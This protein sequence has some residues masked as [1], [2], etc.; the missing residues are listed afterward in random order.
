[1]STL[2]GN[3]LYEKNHLYSDQHIQEIA[4]L[5]NTLVIYIKPS[6]DGPLP[7]T[8]I[9]PETKLINKS[10]INTNK[11]III[12]GISNFSSILINN[13]F[14]LTKEE[15]NSYTFDIEKENEFSIMTFNVFYNNCDK[16]QEIDE[17]IK[18]PKPTLICTQEAN[19]EDDY[20]FPNYTFIGNSGDDDS[21][22]IVAAYK[23]NNLDN[24]DNIDKI[25]T[26]L[27]HNFKRYGILFD[28]KNIKIANLHLAGGRGYDQFLFK[29]KDLFTKILNFKLELL[30]KIIEKKPDII[31][32]DFNSVLP[33]KDQESEDLYLQSQYEYFKK[34]L[35]R[36]LNEEEIKKIKDINN[37]PYERLI[38]SGYTY[39]KPENN[40]LFTNILGK[41]IV[42]CI[43]Y[44]K[45]K[46]KLLSCNI[47]DILD[48]YTD[49]KDCISD[50]NPVIAD[51]EIIELDDLL[52]YKKKYFK[53]KNKYLKNKKN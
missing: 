40:N 29:S 27:N 4:F 41:T 15:Y 48:N 14:N 10:N 18:Y 17:K 22:E 7:T 35:Q 30:K 45:E 51:F 52:I 5:L 31:L 33:M 53:Y 21:R 6:F 46:L 16:L 25:T 50:H 2:T 39:A 38:S 44:K 43:W 49:K 8:K 19:L 3:D 23:L 37:I 34:K 28:Y 11:V 42:D 47:I 13:K 32:G 1:M 26:E 24:I 20:K 9:K 12:E 36:E